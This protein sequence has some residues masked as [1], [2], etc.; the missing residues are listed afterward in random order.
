MNQKRLTKPPYQLVQRDKTIDKK[1]C[2]QI[3]LHAWKTQFEPVMST[4]DNKDN[5][6]HRSGLN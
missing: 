3:M 2:P 4:V 5:H 1:R 6:S